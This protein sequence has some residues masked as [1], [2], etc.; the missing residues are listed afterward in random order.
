MP[1]K[2]NLFPHLNIIKKD[3]G[4]LAAT[5]SEDEKKS[6]KHLTKQ[7]FNQH[8]HFSEVSKSQGD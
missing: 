5:I 2:L 6:V 1:E 4:E 3:L 7:F 8:S